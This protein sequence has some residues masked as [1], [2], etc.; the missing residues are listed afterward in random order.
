MGGAGLSLR[1]TVPGKGDRNRNLETWIGTEP[2]RVRNG[3]E[4][5]DSEL[6]P[7]TKTGGLRELLSIR[8]RT[9]FQVINGKVWYAEHAKI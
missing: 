6:P 8:N 3:N 2:N 1:F 4:S 7:A 5:E 9:I